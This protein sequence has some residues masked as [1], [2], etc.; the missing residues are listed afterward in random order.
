MQNEATTTSFGVHVGLQHTTPAEL[1]PLYR[2][3]EDLGFDWISVWDHFYAGT[4]RPD[5]A[6]CLEAVAMH[7]AL[8]CSTERVRCGALVYSIGYRHPAI[9]AKA[10]TTIDLLSGGRAEMGLGAGWAEVEYRAYGIDFPPIG[11]RMDQLDEGVRVLRSL[12]HDQPEGGDR[13]DGA[14]ADFSGD[15]FT[16]RSAR[17]EPRPIQR[18]LPIWIGGT[19]E[20]RTLPIAAR[21]ADG[22]NAPFVSPEELA[23]LRGRL[24]GLAR[25]AGRAP[26]EIRCAVN[27][28]LAFTEDSLHQQF[29]AL[30]ERVRPGVLTGSDDEI[31][32]R[33]GAYVDAGA[34]Q[35]NLALRAPF[36]VDALD[37]F[38]DLLGLAGRS[39][40]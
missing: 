24:V 2:H 5:D 9:L 38:A 22:W 26:D 40:S 3:I 33:I 11:T 20:R 32:D 17:N 19:G 13:A 36:D 14:G 21:H 7:A 37:R 16:L 1:I 35:I 31:V 4:G 10:I 15:W 25:E 39:S 34:D 12:L 29:G 30:V 28:G 18:R 23:R 8:A 6:S 27:L